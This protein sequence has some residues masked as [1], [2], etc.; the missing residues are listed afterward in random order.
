MF[1]ISSGSPKWPIGMFRAMK[2]QGLPDEA[3]QAVRDGQAS[4][5]A[6]AATNAST[7]LCIEVDA[8][9]ITRNTVNLLKTPIVNPSSVSRPRIDGDDVSRSTNIADGPNGKAKAFKA[10]AAKR[11][12]KAAPKK[13]AAKKVAVPKTK[14]TQK[15]DRRAREQREAHAPAL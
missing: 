13:V 2:A 8:V 15:L 6:R 1:A 7:A 9:T 11:R 14:E 3:I 12:A 5:S 10:A 4:S